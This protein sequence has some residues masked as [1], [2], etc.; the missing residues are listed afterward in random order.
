MFYTSWEGIDGSGKTTI[1]QI[2]ADH[3]KRIVEKIGG[4]Q[5][6][7]ITTKEPSGVIREIILD[8]DNK[9]GIT[10]MGRMFLYMADRAIH[11]DKVLVPNKDTNNVILCDRGLLS[12]LVY[13][14]ETTGLNYE[15]LLNLSLVAC[16][17]IVPDVIVRLECNDETSRQRI[18]ARKEKLNYFDKMNNDFFKKLIQGYDDAQ[19]YLES[20][21]EIKFINVVT[22]DKTI[23][24]VCEEV[25]YALDRFKK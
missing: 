14:N 21:T 18:Y 19:K 7:V 4:H 20:Y 11:T 8:P 25:I 2:V 24:E 5:P 17:N 23:K 1:M 12:T 3:Y 15:T 9:I 6:K 22:D 10:E 13:Q 16:R